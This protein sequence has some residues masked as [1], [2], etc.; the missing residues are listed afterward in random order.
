MGCAY[1]SY[2]EKIFLIIKTPKYK[3]SDQGFLNRIGQEKQ[4]ILY[5]EFMPYKII[6]KRNFVC[7]G[8]KCLSKKAFL[9]KIGLSD[10][11]TNILDLI[12]EGKPLPF[13]KSS[14]Q[15]FEPSNFTQKNNRFFYK[16]KNKE[17]KF[18]DYRKKIIIVLR[19]L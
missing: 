5:K 16:V 13:F 9:R 6:I 19:K 12:L 10:Y 8:E 11:P 17:I 4:L 2:T 3:L 14:N 18:K 15:S 7:E 1:K